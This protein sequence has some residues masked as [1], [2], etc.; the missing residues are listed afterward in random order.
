MQLRVRRE[1]FSVADGYLFTVLTWLPYVKLDLSDL[2]NIAAYKARIGARPKVREALV[3][4][5]S[6]K[7]VELYR[8]RSQS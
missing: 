8:R 2:S 1:R 4:E 6:S 5:G 3:K 7:T